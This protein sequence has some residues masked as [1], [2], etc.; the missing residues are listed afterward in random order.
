MLLF[1]GSGKA[2]CNIVDDFYRDNPLK[3]IMKLIQKEEQKFYGIAYDTSEELKALKNIPEENKVLIGKTK[4]KLK[5][6][7]GDRELGKRAVREEMSLIRNAIAKGMLA[8][9]E[10]AFIFSSLGGGTGAA[11]ASL[12]CEE[13]KKNYKETKVIGVFILPAHSEGMLYRKNAEKSFKESLTCFDGIVILDNNVLVDRGYDIVEAREIVNK[14][15]K[16]FFS[17]A[18]ESIFNNFLEKISTIAY[19]ELWDKKLAIKDIIEKML[20]EDV[21]FK[22]NLSYCEKLLLL[23]KGDLSRCYAHDFALGW[24][25]NKFGIELEYKLININKKPEIGM[26]IAGIDNQ[27]IKKRIFIGSE[28]KQAEKKQIKTGLED[29]LKDINSFL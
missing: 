26:I 4:T 13:I 19:A 21:F 16:S 2:G 20:R 15:I 3:K 7:G 5:G 27:E 22:V 14:T 11:S 9:P 25:K 1:I 23:I 10:F 18:D 24:I 12:V 6:T 29:L 17:I 28:E 8:A